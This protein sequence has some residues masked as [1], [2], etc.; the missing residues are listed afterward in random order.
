[1]QF[2]LLKIDPNKFTRFSLTKVVPPPVNVA[3]NVNTTGATT[4]AAVAAA[5]SQAATI[6][7]TQPVAFN[8]WNL[9]ADVC[10]RYD[11]INGPTE[12]IIQTAMVA[13]V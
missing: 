3:T 9:P 11:S 12:I 7:A 5:T 4:P 13:F 8:S 6:A 10:D 2:L 1:M